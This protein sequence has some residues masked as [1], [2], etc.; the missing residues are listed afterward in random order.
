MSPK[1]PL[2]QT[3]RRARAIERV[4]KVA[5]DVV[6]SSGTGSLR[7]VAQRARVPLS[8]L[9]RH[10]RDGD[11]LVL[12]AQRATVQALHR[13]F[14]DR[15]TEGGRG[16][17]TGL[18]ALDAIWSSL[19][20]M[21]AGAPAMVRLLTLAESEDTFTAASTALLEDGI[22]AVLGP[23]LDRLT[24]APDR[25]A[26]LIRIALEGLTIELARARTVDD[27]AALDQAYAD[28]RELVARF[29]MEREAAER[30]EGLEAIPLPW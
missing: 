19:R 14:R 7:E 17:P 20:S 15:A 30:V 12:A 4:L 16:L 25:M 1:L 10:F 6:G 3:P 11:D 8:E 21:R 2:P 13:K 18:E 22:R 26:V 28:L 23:E 5:L 9:R 24:L 27:L 29:A